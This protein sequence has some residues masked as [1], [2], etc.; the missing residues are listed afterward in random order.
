MT[1]ALIILAAI[2][3]ILTYY[4]TATLRNAA[5]LQAENA[6]LQ[7]RSAHLTAENH[8]LEEQLG[9]LAA[10]QRRDFELMARRIIETES[11]S[12]R[13]SQNREIDR[14]LAPLKQDISRFRERVEEC[15]SHEARERFSLSEKIKD[16]IEAN[17]SIGRQA[18]ELSTA[19]RGNSKTQGDWGELVLETLLEKSGLRRGEEYEV[20]LT[21]DEKGRTLRSDTGAGLRPDVVIRYP[22]RGFMVIDSK[23]SLS[24]FTEMVNADTPEEREAASRRHLTSVMKHVQELSDKRY[25]EYVGSEGRLDFVMMFIPNEGAYSAAMTADPSL[26]EKA[27]DRRVVIASPTQLMGALRIVAQMWRHDRQARNA[28]D[29]ARRSGQMYD[30]LAAFVDDLLKVERALTTA[31][32]T[33]DE[34]KK[35]LSTGKGNLLGRAEKLRALGV[36]VTR[37]LSVVPEPD[38]D[39]EPDEA[40]SATQSLR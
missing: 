39:D 10:E 19:L 17:R 9:G 5:R 32:T 7:E 36:K 35:K 33:L 3:L 12:L 38:D 15:Y 30:K 8:R 21:A 34:A 28:A 14:L 18:E 37:Q 26:W 40:D 2:S 31:A 29:I 16:L 27:Y 6:R 4:L 22:D 24:A 20:Q 11:G 13:E 1:I 23:V 25:E